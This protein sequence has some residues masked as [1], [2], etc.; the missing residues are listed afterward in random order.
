MSCMSVMQPGLG[1]HFRALPAKDKPC[2][3]HVLSL[4]KEGRR[5]LLGPEGFPQEFMHPAG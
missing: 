3:H 1:N 2:R 4:G 5:G